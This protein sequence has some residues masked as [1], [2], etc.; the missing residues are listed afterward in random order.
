VIVAQ[1]G[2]AGGRAPLDVTL[3]GS[4]NGLNNGNLAGGVRDARELD[5][6]FARSRHSRLTSGSHPK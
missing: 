4:R 3:N 1:A 6:R 5:L 2:F